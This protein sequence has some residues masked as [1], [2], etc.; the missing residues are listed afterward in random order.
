MA[1]LDISRKLKANFSKLNRIFT[2]LKWP[3]SH[4]IWDQNVAFLPNYSILAVTRAQSMRIW[5]YGPI[6]QPIAAA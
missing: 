4:R 2:G 6:P 1:M 5:N 3:R